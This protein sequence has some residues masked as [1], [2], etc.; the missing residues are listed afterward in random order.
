MDI[1]TNEADRL[2]NGPAKDEETYGMSIA[3]VNVVC[4]GDAAEILSRCRNVLTLVLTRSKDTWPSVAE[5]SRILPKWFTEAC[6]GEIDPAEQEAEIA[7]VKSLPMEEGMMA[8]WSI[9]VWTGAFN[10]NW[11]S[12][13]WWNAEIVNDDHLRVWVAVDG[14]PYSEGVLRWLLLAAGAQRIE[15]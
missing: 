9:G 3:E 2:L 12:W 8:P 1:D 11:R 4:L 13:F 15:F 6:S 14:W 5:W 7:R 10:L